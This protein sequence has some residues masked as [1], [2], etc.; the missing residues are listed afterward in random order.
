MDESL[1]DSEGAQAIP[2]GQTSP[3]SANGSPPLGREGEAS[4]SENP[5]SD[6]GIAK[7]VETSG[8]EYP[9]TALV[10]PSG[11][12]IEQEL[13]SLS[14]AP[15]RRI[16]KDFLGFAPS[17]DALRKFAEKYPDRWANALS[18]LSQLGGYKKDVT[19]TNNIIM[20]GHMDDSA[21]RRRMAELESKLGVSG[22]MISAE[23]QMP[24]RRLQESSPSS[25]NII[26]VKA[27]VKP[28]N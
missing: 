28:D 8:R 16:L 2:S 15:F 19:E 25:D 5:A 12:D 26:D 17:P 18:T 24:S 22:N 3:A 20:I 7:E 6:G 9:K 13:E 10:E 27:T 14:R 21:L 11:E 1:L 23:V 4:P